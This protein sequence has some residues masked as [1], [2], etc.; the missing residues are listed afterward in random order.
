MDAVERDEMV[1]NICQKLLEKE[2]RAYDV[3]NIPHDVEG[4]YCIGDVSGA[5]RQFYLGEPTVNKSE[6]NYRDKCL[7]WP[8]T[9]YG[10][11]SDINKR[12][13][14]HKRQDLDIDEFS[15]SSKQWVKATNKICKLC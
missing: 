10:G 5:P 9:S 14:R 11:A 2:W 7:G 12:P 3:E 15:V 1:S 6:R 4:I 13:Q 8:V